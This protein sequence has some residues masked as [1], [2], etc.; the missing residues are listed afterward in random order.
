MS[1]E[2][3]KDPNDYTESTS[4]QSRD[5]RKSKVWSHGLFECFGD[6]TACLYSWCCP[7]CAAGEIQRDGEIGSFFLGCMLLCLCEPCHPCCVTGQLREKLGIEGS[8]PLDCCTWVFCPVCQ[9]TRELR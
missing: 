4:I 1:Y 5:H 6:C 8:C 7:C 9:L 3:V 2:E